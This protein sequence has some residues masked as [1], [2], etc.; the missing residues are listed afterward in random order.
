MRGQETMS[1][2][3]QTE[4]ELP[5]HTQSEGEVPQQ[6]IKCKQHKHS[7]RNTPCLEA[8]R[9]SKTKNSREPSGFELC[10]FFKTNIPPKSV[11]SNDL[12]FKS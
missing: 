12:W 8:T 2:A 1:S 6:Q 7:G 11:S 3:H 5:T 9:S 10:L 4:I